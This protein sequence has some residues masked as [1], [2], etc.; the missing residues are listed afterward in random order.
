MPFASAR[1]LA[2]TLVLGPSCSLNPSS[3]PIPLSLVHALALALALLGQ[4]QDQ[5]IVFAKNMELD[6][7]TQNPQ[8][9]LELLF[10]LSQH[11]S[12]EETIEKHAIN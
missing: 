3:G 11:I 6:L 5:D 12:A 7:K 2:L 4:V 9:M 1:A 8:Q 10:S